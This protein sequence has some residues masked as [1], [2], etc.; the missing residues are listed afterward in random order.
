[1]AETGKMA[2]TTEDL[3]YKHIKNAIRNG[4][5]PSGMRLIPESLAAEFGV[6]RMPVRQA[7]RKLTTEGF[8]SSLPNR[9]LVVSKIDLAAMKEIFEM[10]AV[11]EGLAIRLALE[12]MNPGHKIKLENNLVVMEQHIGNTDHWSLLHR[13]FHEDIYRHCGRPMLLQQ[14]SNL[15]T[16][17]EPYMKI[18]ISDTVFQQ[19]ALLGHR[20]IID[21]INNKSAETCE[22]IMREHI[23]NTIPDL[24]ELYCKQ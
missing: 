13:Q 10:R 11:L 4:V 15:L 19:H 21:A 17:V 7:L 12:N 24:N 23:M 14:I 9:R 8:V 18:W 20:D 2:E 6:S 5:Y 1:M 16:M 3:M 22:Q